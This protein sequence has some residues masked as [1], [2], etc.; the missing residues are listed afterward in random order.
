MDINLLKDKEVEEGKSRKKTGSVGIELTRPKKEKDDTKKQVKKGGMSEFFTKLFKRKK[1]ERILSQKVVKKEENVRKV[2]HDKIKE[3]KK[4]KKEDILQVEIDQKAGSS[5]KIVREEPKPIKIEKQEPK[6]ISK[7]KGEMEPNAGDR[8]KEEDKKPKRKFFTWS[9]PKDDAGKQKKDISTKKGDSKKTSDEKLTKIIPL[10]E[11]I[12]SLDVNLIPDDVLVKLEP[13]SKLQ[14]LA[15]AVGIIAVLVGLIY[16][17][18]MYQESKIEGDIQEVMI[19]IDSVE[20]ELNNLGDI[21]EDAL[22][23]KRQ[24]DSVSQLLNS[25]IYWS[26]FLAYLEKYTL[27]NVYYKNLAA[28]KAGVVTLTASAVDLATLA[29]QYLLFQNAS[30]FV[31]NVTIESAVSAQETEDT[32]IASDAVDFS[33]SLTK[34]IW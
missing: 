3:L 6:I 26:Q 11:R 5:K 28:T 13:K 31:E 27:S 25:H 19:E 16:G 10:E 14:Q 4:E 23:L 20:L 12:Q 24:I 21:R 1:K 29:D 30:D 22:V 33:I 9:S 8:E 15:L 2:S 17:Y 18:M 32:E 7:D 34:L